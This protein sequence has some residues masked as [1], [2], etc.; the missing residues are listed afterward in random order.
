MSQE[1]ISPEGTISSERRDGIFLIG[2]NRPSKRNGLSEKMVVELGQAFDDFEHDPEAR[3]AVLH[4]HGDHFTAG[5]QL[6]QLAPWVAAGR[7]LAPEGAVDPFDLR[8][9]LRTKPV[10]AAVQGICYTAGIELMLAA[11]I[12][13]SADDARFSQLEVKRGIM[14]NHGA[15]I[16]I[17]E[18]A[19]WGNAMLYLLT[20]DEFDAQ[21][22]C[23]LGSFRRSCQLA[24][25]L[26]VQ[27][28]LQSESLNKPRSRFGRP[29][30]ARAK[31]F[32]EDMM[33]RRPNS[34]ASTNNC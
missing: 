20:G 25:S 10:V 29:L 19:G 33:R 8:A 13:V 32:A 24:A 2:I 14:A 1:A 16:R 6:D 26:I 28:K 22:A 7:H 30:P 27:S 31:R 5:L 9:P 21:T 4:A 12:V 17:V 15:T 3:V 23:A 34:D 18:R 11:D